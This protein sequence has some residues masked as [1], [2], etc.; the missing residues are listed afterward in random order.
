MPDYQPDLSG[1]NVQVPM[2]NAHFSGLPSVPTGPVALN[3]AP[4]QPAP[5]NTAPKVAPAPS[6]TMSPSTP[7]TGT[8]RKNSANSTQESAEEAGRQMAEEDKRRR[9]TAASAR[10]RVKKK[11]RE[12][13][14]E[15]T[16]KE[17]TDKNEILEAR[18]SQ[19]ELEN[20]W[21][22]GLIM[23]KNG[24]DEQ[25]E[26]DISDM[27]KKFLASQKADGSSTSDLKRGVGTL[28]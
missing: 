25:S 9:N 6:V 21:L 19:L 4:I 24:A 7:I 13:A 28:V 16:V 26:Q 1:S 27:F 8:K 20:H 3:Q 5:I 2:H 18:V 23:E 14:L 12:A 10:F 11:Q 22:R 17:T 15:Q